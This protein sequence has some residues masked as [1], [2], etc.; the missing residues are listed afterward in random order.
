MT[1][2]AQLL[3][4]IRDR[5]DEATATMWS[6]DQLRTW[7]NE[8][9]RDLARRTETLLDR[10]TIPV[11]AGTREYSVP[12]D[13]LKINR[14]EYYVSA[15]DSIYP[16]E[17]RQFNAMDAVWHTQQAINSGTPIYFTTWGFPPNAKVILYPTP[18]VAGTLRLFVYRLP[19]ELATSTSAD[20]NTT[21]EV[22][23]G[24]DDL[25]IDYVEYTALRRDRDPRWQEAKQLY[26]E[27]I[28]DFWNLSRELSD[29]GG[30]ITP[31]SDYGLPAW[32]I[33]DI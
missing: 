15:T 2:Q 14:A 18:S 30:V 8:G 12:T 22:P 26:E 29:Q 4:R 21:V 27:R 13:V 33:H 16:L 31:Y 9:A 6:D 5:L 1:T 11:I 32:L 3:T 19:A 20:A 24:W 28:N 7:I 17:Y 23:A 10:D 25:V